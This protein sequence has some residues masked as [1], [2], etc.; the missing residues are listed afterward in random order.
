MASRRRAPARRGRPRRGGGGFHLPSVTIPPDVIRSLVGLTLLVLGV[1][2]LVM[3]ALPSEKGTLTDWARTVVLPNFGTGRWLLP[4]FLLVAGGLIEWRPLGPGWRTRLVAAMVAYAALLGLFEFLPVRGGGRIGTF[5]ADAMSSLVTRT[6][7]EVVLAAVFV[8]G[9]LIT[10][11][12]RLAEF[13]AP[14]WRGLRSLGTA[15]AQAPDAAA[16]RGAARP[17]RTAVVDRGQG[18]LPNGDQDEGTPVRRSPAPVPSEAPMSQT[19]VSGGLRGGA[20]ARAGGGLRGATAVAVDLLEAEDGYLPEGP[21]WVLPPIDLL[22]IVPD[23]PIT[24]TRANH[25][26]NI[27]IIEDKLNSF[28][29]PASVVATN[30]GP[31]VT[32]YEVRPERHIKLSRIEGLADDL[33]MALAA[34]TI[35]IEAP[36]PGKDVVGIEIPNVKSEIVSFR[37]LLEESKMLDA[38]S[39][40]SFAL[41]R[42]VSGKPYAV[43]LA[44]MPHLLVAGA[45]GSGK[46]V[47]INALITSILMHATPEEVKLILI[48]LKRVEL[49]PYDALPH[50]IR[51]VLVEPNEA[52]A[53]L[54]G[55]VRQMEERYKALAG[56]SVR[57]IAAFNEH[58]DV[59]PEKRLPYIVIII[60][61]LADLIMREGQKVEEPIVKIAQKAR[62]VGIHLVLATQRPSVN[63]VTGLIKA[64]VPSRMAFAMASMIDSRTV[65]D[66]P[67][68]EDLIGRGDMLYQPVDLPRP[69]RLQGVFV[70]DVEVNAVG[71]HW[72]ALAKGRTFYDDSFMAFGEDDG[73]GNGQFRWLAA[74]A[75]DDLVVDAAELVT[76][77]NKASTSML[78]TKLKVGF[79]RASRLMDELERYGIIGPGDPRNPAVPRIVYGRDNWLVSHADIDDPGL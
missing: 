14:F 46:S 33:A 28:G 13:V 58:K 67:G 72:R 71:D 18:R 22:T 24:T 7:A 56:M 5:L 52:K 43:D 31:V 61:E 50:L 76:T 73:N 45:T 11:N 23:P 38:E 40:L 16:A 30:T 63:V 74:M 68:A 12:L 34:R 54:N 2:T 25:A 51:P 17:A 41:G 55:A 49:A 37:R 32:Q 42:D 35:R 4:I 47:C 27:R 21:D 29:I 39:R 26:D 69:I 62:A 60:D 19:V 59:P 79:S 65:L 15:V 48:D 44:K 70:S 66:A 57:N 77:L 53:A 75:D 1:V 20:E 64:N 36:I 8:G 10:A 6:G 78:Q 9:I 3:L